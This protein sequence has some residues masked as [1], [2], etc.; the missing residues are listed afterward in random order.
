MSASPT[1]D[2]GH[3]HLTRHARRIELVLHE[4][5][6]RADDHSRQHRS[7]PG[8]LRESIAGFESDLRSVRQ[9]MSGLRHRRFV[10]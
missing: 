10:R 3:H 6:V 1:A 2:T 4:L 5:R 7:V 9:R 8:P